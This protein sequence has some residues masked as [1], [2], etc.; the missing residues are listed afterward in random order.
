MNFLKQT[1][2]RRHIYNDLS[3]EM[4]QHLDEKT[5]QIMRHEGLDREE[6]ELRARRAFGNRTV[7]EERG[8][9]PWQWVRLE[10]ILRDISF[11]AR[12]LRRSPGFTLIAILT[13]TLGVG[14]N[15]AVFS[16]LNGLLLRPLPVPNARDLAMLRIE[17]TRFA[18]SFC[19]PLFRALEKRHDVFWDVFAF[20]SDTFQYRGQNGNEQISGSLVSGQ[21]F[22]ALGT[23]PERG[24]VLTPNDD[25]KEGGAEGFGAVVS[26]SFWKTHLNSD[27]NV[28]GRKL[29]LNG[30]SFTVV[31]VMPAGFSGADATSRPEIYLPLSA[32]PLVDAPYD[33]LGQGYR[34]WWLRVGARLNPGVS[35][36]QANAALM[37]ISPQVLKEAIPDPKWTF[38]KANRDAM[39]VYAES[40]TAGYSYLRQEYRN[41]LLVTFALCALVLLLACVNLASLLLA[42]SAARER[43]IA[44]RLAIG[45]TRVRLIQ[46]LLVD[47][48]LLAVLGAG[49]GLAFAPLASRIV[50]A[51]LTGG[52]QHLY[53][54]AGL[55][56]RVVLFATSAA[57]LSTL[58]VGL[59][60]AFQATSGDLMQHMK[61]GARGTSKAEHRRLLPKVLLTV[62][63]ALAMVLV[64]G[65]GLLG[66]SL[67]RL[68]HSSQGFDPHSLLEVDI[69]PDRQSLE[70]DALMRMYRDISDRIATLPGVRAVGY[71]SVPPL[72]GS[73]MMG[74]KH[75]AGGGD[76]DIYNN[77]VGQG[78][79]SA[80]RTPILE[81]RDFTWQDK[82]EEGHDIIV[83]QAAAK[84]FY[85]GQDALGK[86]LGDND[87]K[88]PHSYTIVGVVAD[89]KYSSLKEPAPPTV[90]FPLGFYKEF[91]KPSF[92]LMVRYAGPVAPLAVAIR[93]I[94]TS[95]SPD[96]PAPD[97]RTMESYIDGSIAAERV[98]ALLA[99]FFG[100]SALLVTGIGLYGVL[101]YSTARRTSE[102]GIR[103]ALGA[104]RAQVIALIFRE[105]I[106]V[107]LSGCIAGLATAVLASRALSAFLYS[108]SPRDPWVLSASLIALCLIAAIASLVPAMRAA[109]VDPMK[110]LRSE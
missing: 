105:N 52:R 32:E 1:F 61:D 9:E 94:L 37:T 17:P 10:N 89:T 73:I 58:L 21:F 4:R 12:L 92:T 57:L 93:G 64:T 49:A 28:L 33:M 75:A 79:F 31:G 7:I 84:M 3:E 99:I 53:L 38:F 69:D 47:S 20:D 67:F 29:M 81:G 5:E 103:M 104:A 2:R 50:V 39:H 6:A 88:T 86:T 27:P 59:L 43:E 15:T 65:A 107:A 106:W 63:V 98:M 101:A 30:V 35:L 14:A 13:L 91:K 48:L 108:T 96:I 72:S 102:I 97:F 22:D 82:P 90:Y 34:S 85:P 78:Y 56:W 8:R 76:R 110:A 36:A 83:N 54:D 66:A 51:M 11:S 95:A 18:Y 25:R 19:A 62:E 77:N 26:D 55:D 23:A 45:A 68:Y 74:S 44:T 42:R 16:L 80:M 71:S 46:Q 24:R 87:G 60:P 41:P 109:S 40:G 70:G 100:I